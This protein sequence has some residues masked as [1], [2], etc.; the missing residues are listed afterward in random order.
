MPIFNIYSHVIL[1]VK[2]SHLENLTP[3]IPEILSDFVH[4]VYYFWPYSST[5]AY[6]IF[7]PIQPDS[8]ENYGADIWQRAQGNDH[9]HINSWYYSAIL[10][11]GH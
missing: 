5:V 4:V 7:I 6:V 10:K 1:L 2:S 11:N 3:S 9:G 8:Q